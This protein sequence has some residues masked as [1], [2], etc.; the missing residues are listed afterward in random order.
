MQQGGYWLVQQSVSS[1]QAG[2]RV[3]ELQL[4]WIDR[5]WGDL[6]SSLCLFAWKSPPLGSQL[7]GCLSPGRLNVGVSYPPPDPIHLNRHRHGQDHGVV[8]FPVGFQSLRL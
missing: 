7:L 1:K 2:S 4:Q 3:L 6:P 5:V 8:S